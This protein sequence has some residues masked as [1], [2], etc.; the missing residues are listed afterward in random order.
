M[1]TRTIRSLSGGQLTV[2]PRK[3]ERMLAGRKDQP[4]ISYFLH[5]QGST[6]TFYAYRPR[7][8]AF[9]A[10]LPELCETIAVPE[11]QAEILRIAAY[12]PLEEYADTSRL[13]SLGLHVPELRS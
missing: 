1:S 5:V 3:D 8:R 13:R 2:D 4:S 10:D 7:Q 9:G 11:L 12:E 6:H